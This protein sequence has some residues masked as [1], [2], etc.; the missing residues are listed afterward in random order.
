MPDGGSELLQDPYIVPVNTN[1]NN[2]NNLSNYI[3]QY[4]DKYTMDELKEITRNCLYR[5][6]KSVGDLISEFN[7][8]DR[9][10][11]GVISLLDFKDVMNNMIQIDPKLISFF[12]F[13][14]I[15]FF[16]FYTWMKFV[17]YLEIKIIRI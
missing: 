2:N 7:R 17:V 14:F 8:R 13:L 16:N 5:A 12:I 3:P 15:I 9:D 11:K 1:D 4:S 10:G 6:E